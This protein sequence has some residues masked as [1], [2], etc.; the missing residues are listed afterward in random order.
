MIDRSPLSFRSV[1]YGLTSGTTIMLP[2]CRMA[3]ASR[4][5]RAWLS[6]KLTL[7]SFARLTMLRLTTTAPTMDVTPRTCL[8]LM[9]KRMLHST[10]DPRPSTLDTPHRAPLHPAPLHQ[11]PGAR[12]PAPPHP[13]PQRLAP[14]HPAPQH[15]APQ[16]PAPSPQH[17]APFCSFP[18]RPQPKLV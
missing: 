12:H 18:L 6:S 10:L 7:A 17:P 2:R 15:P 14:Q 1:S 9:P 5:A 3:L 4:S 13:A 11:I 16:H 8:P